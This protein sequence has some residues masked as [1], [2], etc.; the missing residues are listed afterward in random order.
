MVKNLEKSPKLNLALVT[1]TCCSQW[2]LVVL[3]ILE[4]MTLV[5]EAKSNNVK[6][7]LIVKAHFIE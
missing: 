6:V 5:A 7:L 2:I 4:F 3:I 1:A